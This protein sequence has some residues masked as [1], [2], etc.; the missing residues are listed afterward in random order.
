MLINK[1]IMAVF[2]A[3]VIVLSGC[4]LKK[5]VVNTTGLFMD[6]VANSFFQENDLDFAGEAIPANLKLLDGLIQASGYENEG[7]LLKGCKL[8]SMYAMGYLE[9]ATM[10]MKKDR[11]NTARA[12][13][14][15]KRA[16]NY[17]MAVLEKN[18]DFK[19]MIEQGSDLESF[20]KMMIA[21]NKDDV[22]TLFW[23]AFAWSSYIN[24][25]KDSPE[26]V[27]DLPRAK[28]L[29]DRVI[30]LD[31]RYFYGIPHVFMIAYYSMPKMFGG[32]FDKARKEYEKE[33][34]IS[35]GK[36]IL[37]DFYMA[38]YYAVGQQDKKLFEDLIASIRAT[39]DDIIPENLFTLMAKKKAE[40]LEQKMKDYF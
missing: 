7:L 3:V 31:D 32:D 12:K 26:D 10:D 25:S 8:Y 1:K 19:K 39:R 37:A 27:A 34:E 20:Q 28:A 15:Y 14:F 29:I 22:E 33:K 13:N 16:K 2:G 38:K 17:G 40:I 21:F 23:T 9:D 36:F 6:D 11:E 18:N 5:T 24:L 35:G 30:E 4:S